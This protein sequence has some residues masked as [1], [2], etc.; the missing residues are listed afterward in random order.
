MN[1]EHKDQ[2]NLQPES[3]GIKP[4]PIIWFLVVLTAS[5]VLVFLIIQGMLFGFKKME[6]AN[7][8]QPVTALPEGRERKLP[9]EP[10]LQGIPI[11]SG[12]QRSLLPLEEMKKYREDTDKRASSFGWVSKES[13][14]AHLSLESAKKL[15]VDRG[16]PMGSERLVEEVQRAE[17]ARRRV[18]NAEPSAGRIIGEK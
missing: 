17:T 2:H 18:L 13:G 9:P 3:S 5:T 12:D 15:T 11:G 10:R 7:Q 8:A 14:V 1:T 16:L 6:E 4:K